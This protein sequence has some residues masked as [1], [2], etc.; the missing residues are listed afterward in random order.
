MTD[1]PDAEIV[2]HLLAIRGFVWS[3]G[4]TGDPFALL[5]RGAAEPLYPFYERIR[6]AAG[7]VS[8]SGLGFAVV[9]DHSIGAQVLGDPAFGPRVNA[10]DMLR[11]VVP[12]ENSYLGL[13]S[14]GDTRVRAVVTPEL[15]PDRVAAM[16]PRAEE[17][18]GRLLDN[19]DVAAGFDV[20]SG[21]ADRLAPA[22]L[23][24]FLGVPDAHRPAFAEHCPHVSALRDPLL[25][26]DAR[27]QVVHTAA[28]RALLDQ[29]WPEAP[30]PGLLGRLAAAH[31]SGVIDRDEAVGASVMI[32][33]VVAEITTALIA[34]TVLALCDRPDLWARLAAEP[35]LAAR[36][37]AETS[38]YDPPVQL[39]YRV[40]MAGAEIAGQPVPA[41]T[42]VA[43]VTGATNRDPE[44][45]ADP[46]SFDPDRRGEPAPLPGDIPGADLSAMLAGAALTAL[47]A[48]MPAIACAG[49]VK[50]RRW[51]ANVRAV[52][53]L[54]VAARR[55]D[56]AAVP[57]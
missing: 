36:V 9:V 48:R 5:R 17:L 53:R 4:W 50:R 15:A 8:F 56:L 33:A 51:E 35:D 52:L 28:L 46:G 43:V 24:E 31:R 2:P 39:A 26:A 13:R 23:A 22:V 37:V 57:S 6:E 1:T 42:Q 27:A 3:A 49:P 44:V 25:L 55:P 45:Y 18:C 16:R 34:N 20:V 38:R 12:P 21:F 11:R 10:E 30:A 29:A 32:A 54:P 14:P 41:G 19:V 47:A 40:A 7:G